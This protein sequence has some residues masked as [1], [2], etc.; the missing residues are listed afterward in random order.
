MIR[1]NM[2]TKVMIGLIAL[3]A[4]AQIGNAAVKAEVGRSDAFNFLYYE[5]GDAREYITPLLKK[6][7]TNSMGISCYNA[8]STFYVHAMG[9]YWNDT[10]NPDGYKNRQYESVDCSN[11][12]Q[13]YIA[14]GVT[15]N[16]IKNWVKE[17]GYNFGALY[18]DYR[19]DSLFTA[20]G[21]FH[22]D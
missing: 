6:D 22:V 1:K 13:Y 12:Y 3:C 19:G 14:K 10:S 2:L 21:S 11:G 7:T 15:N 5:Y 17:R 8:S 20:N 4:T 9:Y 16:N 18:G